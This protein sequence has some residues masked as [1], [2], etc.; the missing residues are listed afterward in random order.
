MAGLPVIYLATAPWSS[1]AALRTVLVPLWSG[2]WFVVFS[3]SKTGQAWKDTTER[4]P[5]FLRGW[6]WLTTRVPGFRWGF[7]QAYGRFWTNRTRSVFSPAVELEKQPWAFT[8]LTVIRA[9][10]ILPVLKCFLRPLI[11]V[12]AAHLV[13]AQR[14]NEPAVPTQQPTL[15]SPPTTGASASAA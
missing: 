2:Y 7:L 15:P 11:P 12:A 9:L 6:N 3:T 13:L 14:S 10:A 1:S 4:P 5:W 8:G